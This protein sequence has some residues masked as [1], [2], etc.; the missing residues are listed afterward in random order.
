MTGIRRGPARV[1]INAGGEWTDLGVRDVVVKPRAAAEAALVAAE[2]E[3]GVW[4]VTALP[5]PSA[6]PHAPPTQS[7]GTGVEGGHRS[8]HDHAERRR[9]P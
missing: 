9:H 6:A 2:D 8:E 1:Y 4:T 3:P 7:E 5:P